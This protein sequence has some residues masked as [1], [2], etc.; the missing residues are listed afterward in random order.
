MDAPTDSPS[1][2]S[3]GVLWTGRIIKTLV[4]LFMLFDA[5]GKFVRPAPVAAAFQRLEFPL[6]CAP[7]LG[8]ILVVCTFIY[9]IPRTAVLGA[10]LLTGFLGGAIAINFRAGDPLFE[11]WGFPILM[12]TLAWAALWFGNPRLRA[13]FLESPKG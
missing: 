1:A 12:G 11:T 3:P 4:I 9:A 2:A 8:A 13:L 6:K 10:I 5:G 7:Q